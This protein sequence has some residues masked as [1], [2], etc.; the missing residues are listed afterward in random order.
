[1]LPHNFFAFQ[2]SGSFQF[3]EVN[4]ESAFLGPRIWNKPIRF[5]PHL[6][7]R[8]T[9]A[10]EQHNAMDETWVFPMGRWDGTQNRHSVAFDPVGIRLLG[11]GL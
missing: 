2:P 7:Y 8:F 5:L 11:F 1:M 10:I 6:H 4:P 3:G 9:E